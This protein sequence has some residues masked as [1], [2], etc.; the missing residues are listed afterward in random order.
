MG[1]TLKSIPATVSPD[2]SVS[3]SE[4]I[5]LT[6]PASAMVTIV[7][8]GD[9]TLEPAYLS[10]RALEDWNRPEEDEAWRYLEEVI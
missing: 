1:T 7:L 9:E 6:G 10:E 3:L 8:E 5:H 2:G 4:P